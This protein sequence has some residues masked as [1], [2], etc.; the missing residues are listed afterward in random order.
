VTSKRNGRDARAAPLGH[1]V[2]LVL[3]WGH[4][5]MRK[6][7]GPMD[8]RAINVS[9][10]QAKKTEQSGCCADNVLR[11]NSLTNFGRRSRCSDRF[12]VAESDVTS[13]R[14]YRTNAGTRASLAQTG[15]Q[16]AGHFGQLRRRKRVFAE[17]KRRGSGIYRLGVAYSQRVVGRECSAEYEPAR[18]GAV[19]HAIN[20]R[21]HP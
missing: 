14:Q 5:L 16:N 10:L 6:S 17:T 11:I 18:V 15:A 2:D 4:C 13:Y 19:T 20:L 7:L 9:L 12:C 1:S 3:T 8:L 21:R